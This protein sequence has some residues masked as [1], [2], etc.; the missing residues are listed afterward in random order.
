MP[1][2]PRILCVDDQ[3][4]NLT[5]RAMLLQQFGC[6]TIA[7]A[8]HHS[9]LRAL[10]ENE[11]DLMLIDYHLA[12][13]ATG[14]EIARDVR[15]LRPKIPLVMLTGDAKLPE[16]AVECVDAVLVKGQSS[17]RDLFEIIQ[18]L[19]PQA[20]LKPMRPMLIPDKPSKAS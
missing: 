3:E 15:A 20:P 12:G 7:V 6:D 14:E 11:V 13:S 5:I 17:P 8:D 16:S 4:Q 1:G 10:T 2:K 18:K 9:A 19:L